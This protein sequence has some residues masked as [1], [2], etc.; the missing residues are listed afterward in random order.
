MHDGDP[1]QRVVLDHGARAIPLGRFMP[2]SSGALIARAL[3]RL[4]STRRWSP[5]E[6]PRPP[7][8]RTRRYGPG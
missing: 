5:N 1:L 2:D 3:R 6:I 7:A 8:R 4:T